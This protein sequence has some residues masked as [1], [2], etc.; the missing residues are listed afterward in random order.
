MV[1]PNIETVR[2][3]I[4]EPVLSGH[5]LEYL[6][7]YYEGALL[8]KEEEFLFIVT[9]KFEDVKGQYE[10]M[11]A[12]NISIQYIDE[13]M[14]DSLQARN[15]YILGWRT[16]KLLSKYVKQFKP[17]RVLL[18]MLMQFIP[19]IC[20][21]LP[22]NTRVRGIMY[23]IYLYEKDKMPTLRLWA[24][25]LRMWIAARSKVVEKVFVL[26]DADSAKELNSLYHTSKFLF[27]PDPVPEVDLLKCK[28]LRQELEIPS[29][30][31]VFLHF[32]GLDRRKGT[33]EILKAIDLSSQSEL[34]DKTF[35]FAGKINNSIRDEF[36]SR[37]ELVR[38]KVQV[39]V[40]DEF[41]SY[42]FL[43]NL[44][45]SCDV[46]LMPYQLSN[47][48]SGVI[49]YAAVFDKPVIGPSFGLLGKL[50][51]TNKLGYTLNSLTG[52]SIKESFFY[53]NTL[54]VSNYKF[55][56]G[57]DHFKYLIFH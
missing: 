22:R 37:C 56:N 42:D 24:E 4:F 2:T 11:P 49:G 9:Q 28:N 7:H 16:S 29:S 53:S 55:S 19:F 20:W 50:I 38:H 21:L 47:L 14:E 52:Q 8:H 6:H 36:Y 41:C 44:C 17:D 39:L 25:R 43:F 54:T 18:T 5:H 32:G 13:R 35:V 10:W 46:V 12:D 51:R 15:P 26:N 3:L 45:F 30:N 57:L 48:S 23:K 27:L 40:F 33:L 31:K 1:S 34:S